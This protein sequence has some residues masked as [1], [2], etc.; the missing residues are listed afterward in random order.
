MVKKK[1]DFSFEFCQFEKK[2]TRKKNYFKKVFA[3][4]CLF[5]FLL[6]CHHTKQKLFKKINI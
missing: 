3:S 2:K 1:K 5:S 4:F 6:S